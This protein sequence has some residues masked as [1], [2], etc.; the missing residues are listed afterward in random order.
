MS[1]PT[2]KKARRGSGGAEAELLFEKWLKAEGWTYHRA[3]AAGVVRLPGGRTFCKSHD[4]FGCLDFLAFLPAV[5][6]SAVWGVQVTTQSGRAARRKKVAALN[7]PLAWRVSI[8]SHEVTPDPAHRGRRRH[9]WVIEDLGR[10][11]SHARKVV[12]FDP[13]TLPS[14]RD[15]RPS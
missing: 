15:P 13:A 1:A 11:A 7:W 14:V 4:L 8:V 5:A 9:H 10:F 12:P 3:A 2:K 6:G